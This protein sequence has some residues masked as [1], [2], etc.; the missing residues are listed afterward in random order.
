MLNSL[1]DS[2][3]IC[4]RIPHTGTMC[5]LESV[6]AWDDETIQCTVTNHCDPNNPLRRENQLAAITA[7]EYAA[8]AMAVHGALLSNGEASPGFLATLRNVILHVDTLHDQGDILLIHAT[9][10]AGDSGGF[11][12]TFSVN[13]NDRVL[14]EGRATVFNQKQEESS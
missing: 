2:E 14:V 13:A 10:L 11:I 12:Y 6:V 9:R 8:Q 4:A 3:Q 7:A 5:L 1:L